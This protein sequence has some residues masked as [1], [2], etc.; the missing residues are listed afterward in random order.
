MTVWLLGP[1][2]HRITIRDLIWE[3][4]QVWIWVYLVTSEWKCQ[5]KSEIWAQ[6]SKGDDIGWEVVNKI[7]GCEV[8]LKDPKEWEQRNEDRLW[9]KAIFKWNALKYESKVYRRMKTKILS[10]QQRDWQF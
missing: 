6:E 9:T 7:V 5:L 3:R 2:V 8:T 10:L 4:I 1:L